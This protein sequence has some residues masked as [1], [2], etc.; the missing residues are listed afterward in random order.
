MKN[1]AV[2]ALKIFSFQKMS[3]L[4]L[5]LSWNLSTLTEYDFPN[6]RIAAR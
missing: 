1:S 3:C 6:W 5:A 2:L 4:S